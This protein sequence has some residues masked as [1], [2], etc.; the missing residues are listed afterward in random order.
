MM[1]SI[2][3]GSFLNLLQRQGIDTI[4]QAARLGPVRKYMP[5]VRT[6]GI[7]EG[8]HPLHAVRVV[9]MIGN[10]IFPDGLGERRPAGSG[11][12]FFPGIE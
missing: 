6:A 3:S 12:K 11:F 9:K 4:T 8:F 10:G 5:Q 2:E 1:G 7:A